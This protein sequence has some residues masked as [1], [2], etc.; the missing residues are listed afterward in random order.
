[1]KDKEWLKKE[2]EKLYKHDE[3]YLNPDDIVVENYQTV[4]SILELI[5]QLDEPEITDPTI[6]K[7]ETVELPRF[8]ADWIEYIK[9]NRSWLSLYGVLRFSIRTNQEMKEWI[10]KDNSELFSKAWLD[11]YTIEAPKN[12][13]VII[14]NYDDTVFTTELPEDEAMKLIEGWKQ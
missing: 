5:D 4:T 3:A 8:V 2:T 7:K 12:L 1:M 13:Q 14:K 11:G 6:S 10:L 9:E